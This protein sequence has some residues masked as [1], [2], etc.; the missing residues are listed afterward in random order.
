MS[1]RHVLALTES[2]RDLGYPRVVSLEAFR[3]P[4][5]DLVADLLAWLVKAYD[6]LATIPSV[7]SLGSEAERVAFVT[8][9]AEQLASRAQLR[10][11]PRRLYAADSAAVGELIKLVDL[12][13]RAALAFNGTS[14]TSISGGSSSPSAQDDAAK[15]SIRPVGPFHY[16]APSVTA[17]LKRPAVG[18]TGAAMGTGGF[19]S[20]SAG[21]S[22]V[23]VDLSSKA[24]TIRAARELAQEI[25]LNGAH[26]FD[27][28][29]EEAGNKTI[30]AGAL[31]RAIDIPTLSAA[32]QSS[33]AS[34]QSECASLESTVTAMTGDAAALTAKIEKK[35]ADLD[36]RLKRLKSMQGV[37]P[38][39]MDEYERVEAD[40]KKVFDVYVRSVKNVA[41]LENAVEEGARAELDRDEEAELSLKRLQDRIKQEELNMLRGAG[42]DGL[43]DESDVDDE[44]DGDEMLVDDDDDD[45][46]EEDGQDGEDDDDF[47]L[48]RGGGDDDDG[49]EDDEGLDP[50]LRA[51]L[52]RQGGSKSSGRPSH[53]GQ[54]RASRIPG[55]YSDNDASEGEADQS[56]GLDGVP[57]VLLS[58]F[59]FWAFNKGFYRHIKTLDVEVVCPSARVLI[60]Q[61]GTH[62]GW[63]PKTM[64]MMKVCS[65][66]KMMTTRRKTKTTNSTT[67]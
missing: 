17:A 53:A 23:A 34:T 11:N 65:D 38:A 62:P 4:N 58:H 63:E 24:A 13:A 9:V 55:N 46:E 15:L 26:I 2:L 33:L 16:V 42:I 54:Q 47:G 3:Q 52:G 45:E 41:W 5:F 7:K 12:F 64:T 31:A 8:A 59:L 19:G 66:P 25:T 18:S 27:L 44:E 48:G 56:S 57:K 39:Y 10:I 37:R 61:A 20:R 29:D 6:P 21:D 36:R 43:E 51:V 50:D 32:A 1:Y 40:L 22:M 14:E 67:I 49:D 60:D 35:R 28:L 30:R